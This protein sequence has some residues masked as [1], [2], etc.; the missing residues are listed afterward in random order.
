MPRVLIAVTL[1]LLSACGVKPGSVDLPPEVESG[2]FPRTYP[3]IKTDP[4]PYVPPSF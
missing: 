4:P 2:E 1:V 3:D